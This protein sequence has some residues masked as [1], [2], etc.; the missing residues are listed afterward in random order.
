M[1]EL[2]LLVLVKEM[3][4]QLLL[5]GCD[6]LKRCWQLIPPERG[7]EGECSACKVNRPVHCYYKM[8]IRERYLVWLLQTTELESYK[9]HEHKKISGS[10]EYS[11]FL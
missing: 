3:Y 2:S 4:L 9:A 11:K 7:K 8:S 10:M 6:G 5:E 1:G